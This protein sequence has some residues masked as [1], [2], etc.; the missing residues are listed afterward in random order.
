M[1]LFSSGPMNYDSWLSVGGLDWVAG[2]FNKALDTVR[3]PYPHNPPPTNSHT[4]TWKIIVYS[5]QER[6]IQ[7]NSIQTCKNKHCADR[8]PLSPDWKAVDQQ[9]AEAERGDK[10]FQAFWIKKSKDNWSKL[11]FFMIAYLE[12]NQPITLLHGRKCTVE[13]HNSWKWSGAAA[14]GLPTSKEDEDITLKH[15]INRK[16]AVIQ[17]LEIKLLLILSALTGWHI[18]AFCLE[19]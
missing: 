6:S 8:L 11:S 3:C 12:T 19:M 15:R 14:D 18:M 5:E 9:C 10:Q 1:F 4:D 17:T 2:W 13:I 16:G 7:R